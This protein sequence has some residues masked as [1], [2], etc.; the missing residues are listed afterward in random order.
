MVER[1]EREAELRHVLNY[2]HTIGH[3]LEAATGFDR[4]THGEAV[5]L[6]IVA[7]AR[8]AE[9]LGIADS[10]DDRAAGRA[11]ARGGAAGDGPRRCARGDHRRD[12]TRQEGARR[13]RP[14]RPRPRDR[15]FR[16]VF[17]TPRDAIKAAI[18]TLSKR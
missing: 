2:G 12:G 17:D 18:T 10:V 14:V 15:P 3:A 1:D 4:F 7:E 13:A 8:L 11:A 16:I 9:A 5:S 6:G